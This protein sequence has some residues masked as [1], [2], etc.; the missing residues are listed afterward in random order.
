M[1]PVRDQILMFYTYVIQSRKSKYC[2]TGVT[3]DMR[4]R[5]KQHSDG[6][7]TWTKKR[8]HWNLIYYE[9]CLNKED[10]R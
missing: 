9:A 10:A 2:Y 5:L 7:S 3:N 1:S 4:K 8:G 6:K